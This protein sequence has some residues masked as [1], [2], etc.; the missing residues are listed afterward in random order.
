MNIFIFL[1]SLCLAFSV[2]FLSIMSYSF[3][4]RSRAAAAAW[5]LTGL[6]EGQQG[7]TSI[8][9]C[10]GDGD[11]TDRVVGSCRLVLLWHLWSRG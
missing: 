5:V 9:H 8:S 1:D 2:I 3:R 6:G 7:G 4:Q 11:R 10:P